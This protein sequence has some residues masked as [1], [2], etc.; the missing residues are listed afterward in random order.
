MTNTGT[1]H[2]RLQNDTIQYDTNLSIYDEIE[3][4]SKYSNR[5]W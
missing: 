2:I 5:Y 4:Y 1:Q 3:K